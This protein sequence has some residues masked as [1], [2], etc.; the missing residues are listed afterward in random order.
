MDPRFLSFSLVVVAL[1]SFLSVM[2]WSRERRR[3]REAYYRSDALK[4]IAEAHGTG[5][6][7]VLEVLR[8]EEK[9]ARRGRRETQKVSGL[10]TI[11]AGLGMT[12]FLSVVD[13]RDPDPAY[14]VGVIP[15]LV[16]V[17]L[18][19]YAYVLAPKE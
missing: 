18:L 19:V 6:S 10:V 8:E 17:A 4:K 3:E 16:G 11:A 15:V 5:S 14:V 7:V 1:F 2:V 13:R 9:I 12:I